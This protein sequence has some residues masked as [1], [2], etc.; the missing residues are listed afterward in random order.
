MTFRAPSCQEASPGRQSK[1]VKGQGQH[2]NIWHSQDALATQHNLNWISYISFHFILV[3][4]S[5][6]SKWHSKE[7]K[8]AGSGLQMVVIIETSFS[9]VYLSVTLWT[10][11][12]QALLLMGF[13]RQKYWNRL[14]FTS[15]GD[16]PDPGIEPRSPTLQADS[17]LSEPPG[18]SEP[19]NILFSY[20][21][22]Q[23]PRETKKWLKVKGK[24]FNEIWK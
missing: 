19:T 14:P 2:I 12:H 6:K 15:P 5:L 7:G 1:P 11:A 24:V 10:V 9:R 17:L 18:K 23:T 20:P 21:L 4:K 16:L 3:F 22:W 8:N 13:P